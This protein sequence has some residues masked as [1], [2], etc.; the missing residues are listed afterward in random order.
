MTTENVSQT[1][2]TDPVPAPDEPLG[3]FIDRAY[4][5]GQRHG[6]CRIVERYNHF[7]NESPDYGF[8]CWG[9]DYGVVD[10]P[11][12]PTESESFTMGPESS[13]L[14]LL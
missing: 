1:N 4:P 7:H 13:E 6:S 8:V 10:R 12:K 5:S 14:R 3:C 2:P 9:W 11:N